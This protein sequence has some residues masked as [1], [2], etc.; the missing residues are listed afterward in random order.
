VPTCTCADAGVLALSFRGMAG[1]PQTTR[2][3]EHHRVFV[4]RPPLFVLSLGPSG[5]AFMPLVLSPGS[6]TTFNS[7]YTLPSRTLTVVFTTAGRGMPKLLALTL[8]RSRTSYRK[9]AKLLGSETSLAR[10]TGTVKH[11]RF[12]GDYYSTLARR[13]SPFC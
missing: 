13:V 10:S 5:F 4:L 6:K 7:S 11:H 12:S 9:R 2:V 8:A 1:L 3:A